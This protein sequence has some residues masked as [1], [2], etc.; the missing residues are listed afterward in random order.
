MGCWVLRQRMLVWGGGAEIRCGCGGSGTELRGGSG[1]SVLRQ[2][3]ACSG[4][5]DT[6]IAAVPMVY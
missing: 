1:W 6:G 3:C 5:N 2:G 4:A